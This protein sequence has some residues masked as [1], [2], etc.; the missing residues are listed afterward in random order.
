MQIKYCETFRRHDVLPEEVGG[1]RGKLDKTREADRQLL[2]RYV[3]PSRVGQ[4]E[5]EEFMM[6]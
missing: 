6:S 1:A 4:E 2:T 5:M 3:C